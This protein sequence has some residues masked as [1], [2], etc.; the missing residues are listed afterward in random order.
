LFRSELAGV[1]AGLLMVADGFALV[2]SRAA[3]LDGPLTFFVLAGL[4]TAI[5]AR[6]TASAGYTVATGVLAGAAMAVKWSAVWYVPLLAAVLLIPVRGPAPPA[7]RGRAMAGAGVAA[8]ATYLASW[9]GWLATGGGWDRHWLREHGHHEYPVLGVLINLA[10]YH[11]EILR[12]HGTLTATDQFQSQPWQWFLLTQPISFDYSTASACGRPPCASQV[13]LLGT[14][15]LWWS[16]LP[17]IVVLAGWGRDRA[18][19][20]IGAGIAAG[21]LPWF[22]FA[23]AGRSMYYFYA[24][25]AEPFLILAVVFAL[26]LLDRQRYGRYVA[27]GYLA[28]V[29]LCFAYFFPVYTSIPLQ[30]QDW[31]ER[32]W[33]GDYWR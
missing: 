11:W 27:V 30:Y 22:A 19:A 33:L 9:S 13:L 5:K 7:R 3:M 15:I 8:V 16:F 31:L 6:D 1:V 28:A 14:P 25:P 29:A 32:L 10:R 21:L 20:L 23:L 2:L 18:A 17:A 26:R 12:F 4:W 24:A